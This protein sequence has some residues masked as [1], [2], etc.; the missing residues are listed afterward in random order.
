[1]VVL[2]WW[3]RCG[4]DLRDEQPTFEAKRQAWG[5]SLL[6]EDLEALGGE[7]KARG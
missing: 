3:F 6:Q 7:P 2:Y 4:G 5:L 1:M